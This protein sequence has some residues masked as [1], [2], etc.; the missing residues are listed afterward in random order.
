MDLTAVND[1]DIHYVPDNIGN[2]NVDEIV[3]KLRFVEGVCT[4]ARFYGR[5]L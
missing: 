1:G 5:F 3:S 4:I 2:M